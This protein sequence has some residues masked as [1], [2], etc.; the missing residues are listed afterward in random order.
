VII[1]TAVAMTTALCLLGGALRGQR[2]T[3]ARPAIAREG[4]AGEAERHHC[5]GRGLWNAGRRV[6]DVV[7]KA[8]AI[9]DL[10][11]SEGEVVTQR[12]GGLNAR[13]GV[14]ERERVRGEERSEGPQRPRCDALV[15][16]F[17]E[18]AADANIFV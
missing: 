16:S 11:A 2:P 7:G 9:S 17:P 14:A 1:G 5:P 12:Y 18:M 8:E 13:D 3:H 6:R 15:S 10:R 4:E